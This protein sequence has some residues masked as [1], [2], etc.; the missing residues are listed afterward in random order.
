MPPTS[1]KAFRPF[2]L[3]HDDGDNFYIQLQQVIYYGESRFRAILAKI[4]QT[5]VRHHHWMQE[6]LQQEVVCFLS[7]IIFRFMYIDQFT[8]LFVM[9]YAGMATATGQHLEIPII[10]RSLVTSLSLIPKADLPVPFDS[11]FIALLE[12]GTSDEEFG[13]VVRTYAAT[14]WNKKQT[15][16]A[17]SL[18]N[19][20][21]IHKCLDHHHE[22]LLKSNEPR[23]C[24]EPRD[25]EVTVPYQ[26]PEFVPQSRSD[27]AGFQPVMIQIGSD[28]P[29][30]E[31]CEHCTKNSCKVIGRLCATLFAEIQ[32]T[33]QFVSAMAV[34]SQGEVAI[35]VRRCAGFYRLH[36][37]VQE[38]ELLSES[39]TVEGTRRG[40]E[41]QKT[42]RHVTEIAAGELERYKGMPSSAKWTWGETLT[43]DEVLALKRVSKQDVHT[44]YRTDLPPGILSGEYSAT[45]TAPTTNA[46][47]S[48]LPGLVKRVPM[49]TSLLFPSNVGSY[50]LNSDLGSSDDAGTELMEEDGDQ[51]DDEE[52]D[53]ASAAA[54]LWES[55]A[56]SAEGS[57]LAVVE[58]EEEEEEDGDDDAASIA[59]DLW[60]QSAVGGANAPVSTRQEEYDEEHDEEGD[61]DDAAS[62][63]ADLW[64]D[65][66]GT[67]S[68]TDGA[69]MIS[70]TDGAGKMSLAGGAMES[71]PSIGEG[72][73][74][75]ESEGDDAASLAADMWPQ[76]ETGCADAVVPTGQE[77]EEEQDEEEGDKDDTASIRKLG[78]FRFS[79]M[80][81][82]DLS[83]Y[84][85]TQITV[86]NLISVT[87][88]IMVTS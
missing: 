79:N 78:K 72:G 73:E 64:P 49:P 65:G 4:I 43:K 51:S 30:I 80:T 13:R 15:P 47:F 85:N 23:K 6:C 55:V 54:A 88:R 7:R 29:V 82:T 27:G 53:T 77:E 2:S 5:D 41:I 62:A 81:F 38:K 9:A 48:T 35:A 11:A 40:T 84:Y 16:A 57:L 1:I 83:Q 25:I 33:Q 58:E 46:N 10:L 70:S 56:G 19:A 87:C 17:S 68:S 37:R 34:T 39:I 71:A 22:Q 36:E 67:I 8:K 18:L 45:N 50:G 75:E 42:S 52:D 76:S 86:Y 20:N 26:I 69:G 14:W 63:A 66:A 3:Q 61:E 31:R 12:V 59:V 32:A 24:L 21:N 60:P 44:G 74:E 28:A